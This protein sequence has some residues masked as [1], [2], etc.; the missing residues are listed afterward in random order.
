MHRW[1]CGRPPEGRQE[2]AVR[3][4]GVAAFQYADGVRRTVM[5][6]GVRHMSK[7]KK[8]IGKGAD[9][10]GAAVCCVTSADAKFVNGVLSRVQDAYV[11][12]M[13]G[14]DGM[15][16]A[17]A[18]STK[19]LYIDEIVQNVMKSRDSHEAATFK[20]REEESLFKGIIQSRLREIYGQLSES[21]P[22]YRPYIKN[23]KKPGSSWAAG[24]T[25]GVN[26]TASAWSRL[27]ADEKLGFMRISVLAAF[28][29]DH[30]GEY[31]MIKKASPDS[32]PLDDVREYVILDFPSVMQ[33]FF[34]FFSKERKRQVINYSNMFPD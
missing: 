29:A 6:A 4:R 2:F 10:A 27:I 3:P 1:R 22:H 8:G 31:D 20:S 25:S 26:M 18:I 21:S 30:I 23:K 14:L 5:Q 24:F 28:T 34:D 13:D 15:L 7:S 12:D 9:D 17:L 32:P 16:T 11:S 19:V 33:W